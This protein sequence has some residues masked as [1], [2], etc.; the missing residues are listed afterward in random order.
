MMLGCPTLF[1]GVLLVIHIFN[2]EVFQVPHQLYLIT[3]SGGPHRF[4]STSTL[5]FLRNSIVQLFRCL[6][7]QHYYIPVL[8][9]TRSKRGTKCSLA[10]KRFRLIVYLTH[11]YYRCQGLTVFLC[12]SAF[13]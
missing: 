2:I 8:I 5:N 7:I 13:N 12:N 10:K 6:T 4:S 3:Y 11:T 1:S 9:C